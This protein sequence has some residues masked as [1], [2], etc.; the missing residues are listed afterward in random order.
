MTFKFRG[1]ISNGTS[2]G[3]DKFFGFLKSPALSEEVPIFQAVKANY[4]GKVTDPVVIDEELFDG[5]LYWSRIQNIKIFV[6]HND[7]SGFSFFYSFFF[8]LDE[9]ERTTMLI[10]PSPDLDYG[11]MGR[12]RF[13]TPD[14]IRDLYGEE[15]Q[16]YKYFKR[17]YLSKEQFRSMVSVVR[18]GAPDIKVRKLFIGGKI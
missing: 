11:F 7:R 6:S 10:K 9:M 13:L 5:K 3:T 8:K 4:V 16:T 2:G 15:S 1:G 14:E 12:G 17:Q 18:E